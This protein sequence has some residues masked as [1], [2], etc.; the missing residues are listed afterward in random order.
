MAKNA[1]PN[2]IQVAEFRPMDEI[3]AKFK[4][5]AYKWEANVRTIT[6][7]N[8]GHMERYMVRELKMA[9]RLELFFP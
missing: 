1:F 4:K 2:F 7:V 5:I 6:L 3:L 8:H 9:T